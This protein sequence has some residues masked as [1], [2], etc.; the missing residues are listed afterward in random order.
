MRYRG[1]YLES[2]YPVEME[3]EHIFLSVASLELAAADPE[4]AS[5]A[6]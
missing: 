2:G 5:V 4:R 3:Q 1:C 6:E